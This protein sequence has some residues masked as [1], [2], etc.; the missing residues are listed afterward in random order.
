MA[1]GERIREVLKQPQYQPMPV[2]YQVIIIY[3]AT[4][5]YLLDIP[6]SDILTFEKDLFKY[7]D[8]KYPEIL[9]G[10]RETKVLSPENEELLNKAITQCKAER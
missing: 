9:K 8:E 2:E 10:I 3:A 5:K 6:V 7:I 4:R 1:Q